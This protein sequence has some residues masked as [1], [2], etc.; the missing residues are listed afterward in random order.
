MNKL[1]A[2]LL[3]LVAQTAAADTLSGRVVSVANG[4]TLTVLDQD[5]EQHKVR[6]SG[7]D[8]PEKSQPFG[9]RSK[10]SLSDL[11]YGRSVSVEW[12]KRDRY[13][14]IVGRVL[15]GGRDVNFEQVRRGMAWHYKYYQGEQDADRARYAD[16]EIEARTARRGLWADH[17][18]IQPWEW[19]RRVSSAYNG[20][21]FRPRKV[22]IPLET[23][24]AGPRF[25][26]SACPRG[27]TRSLSARPRASSPDAER[28]ATGRSQDWAV[29]AN[30]AREETSNACVG[31]STR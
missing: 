4:D 31:R 1:L 26:H 8:A 9:Q 10:Q 18:P 14:R 13:R 11:S 17:G 23:N 15:E 30:A 2:A 20:E 29:V 19:R 6:L 28:A 25:S 16:A 22:L 5:R 3:L 21:T 27:R 7:I 12:R 24:N